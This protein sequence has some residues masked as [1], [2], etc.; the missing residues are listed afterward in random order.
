MLEEAM[1][2]RVRKIIMPNIDL[3]SFQSMVDLANAHPQHCI[4]MVGL[5]PC[6]V[7]ED[8]EEVL[9]K[10]KEYQENE[11][12]ILQGRSFSGIGEI[13]IDL[14]W[15]ATT[16]DIQVQAFRQ[17]L[18]WAKSLERPVSIHVRDSFQE[19]LK[20]LEEEFDPKLRGVLHCFTGGVEEGKRAIDLG[21][22]LGLGGVLTFKNSNL[23][24]VVKELPLE[25]LVLET[26]SPY[27]SPHPHLGQRNEPAHVLLIAETLAKA[28]GVSL[29]QVARITSR[30]ADKLFK[31]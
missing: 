24:E 15:D 12:D 30:N 20:V 17:Q 14:Y 26:D 16:L 10:L 31:L 3:D 23:R 28:K 5:H 7:K 18:Q 4:P 22:H 1:S 8:F 13:G 9:S 21:F 27:L 29:E 2:H 19:V 6:S 11:K 25:K